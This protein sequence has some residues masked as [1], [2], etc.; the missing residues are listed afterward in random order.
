MSEE[1]LVTLKII[2]T[3]VTCIII[4]LFSFKF[5]TFR[6]LVPGPYLCQIL[7]WGIYRCYQPKRYYQEYQHSHSTLCM[8][9]HIHSF[10]HFH[11]NN[12]ED[13]QDRY[14]LRI[15]IGNQYYFTGQN[16]KKTCYI[17]CNY[18][19]WSLHHIQCNGIY[20]QPTHDKITVTKQTVY[21]RFIC[22]NFYAHF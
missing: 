3:P 7:F 6:S 11:K 13:T 20:A 18:Y 17:I 8:I 10:A 19:G 12:D 16:S 15:Q 9:Q 1:D 2:S 5:G 21:N 4:I 22:E 14:N